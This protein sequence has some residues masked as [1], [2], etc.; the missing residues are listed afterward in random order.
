M[1]FLFLI[2]SASECDALILACKGASLYFLFRSHLSQRSQRFLIARATPVHQSM[3]VKAKRCS[4]GCQSRRVSVIV[5]ETARP[6]GSS[7]SAFEAR[8]K[9]VNDDNRG[10][11]EA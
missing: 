2:V 8:P 5:I 11:G 4:N 3:S 10:S 6:K 9:R 1:W 7:T